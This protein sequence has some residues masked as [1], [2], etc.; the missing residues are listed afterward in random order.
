MK[1]TS[2]L[3]AEKKRNHKRNRR[4]KEDI[5]SVNTPEPP[6]VDDPPHKREL[7]TMRGQMTIHGDIVHSDF[8]DEWEMNK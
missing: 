5:N 8:A 7:G 3:S 2:I 1:K 6:N 4:G